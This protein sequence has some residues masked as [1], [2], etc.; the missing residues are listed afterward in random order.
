MVFLIQSERATIN[1]PEQKVINCGN[2][3]I[4]KVFIERAIFIL[5]LKGIAGTSQAEESEHIKE[6]YMKG[7]MMVESECIKE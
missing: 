3:R 2:E 5:G 6:Q 7:K 4:R 1:C